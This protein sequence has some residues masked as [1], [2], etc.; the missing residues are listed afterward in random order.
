MGVSPST[1]RRWEDPE[2][3][4]RAVL[5]GRER[6]RERDEERDTRVVEL[7]TV[8]ALLPPLAERGRYLTLDE[9]VV[10][11][12]HHQHLTQTELAELLGRNKSTICRELKRHC[13]IHPV[14]DVPSARRYGAYAADR[15]AAARRARPQPRKLETDQP[16]HAHVQQQLM[17][18]WSPEQ[19]AR[20][21]PRVFPEQPERHLC[22]ETIYQALYVQ[23][24]GELRRQIASWLRSGRAIRRPRRHPEAR[25][26]RFSEPMVMVSERPAEV[27]DRAVPGHWEG[28]LIIGKDN[29]SAMVTLVER[30]TRFTMLAALPAGRDALAVRDAL[31]ELFTALPTHLARSLTWDQG[32]EMARHHEVRAATDLEVY[33][34]DPA[35]PWMRGSNENTNGLLRQYFPKG[36]DLS[37]HTPEHLTAVAAELNGRPRKTLD[38]D[39]PA[40]RLASLLA[41]ADE[42]RCCDD[43]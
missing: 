19:I 24:R 18:R 7:A 2:Q 42:Q 8:V 15:A 32:S 17:K 5:R 3:A 16:L 37:V 23:G 41:Q 35:S 4:Q 38:W 36:T 29:G 22:H 12:D 28:D 26:P 13:Y 6:A 40:E 31:I 21:L 11:A 30:S 10:I 43:A 27:A 1:V 33:F 34:C 9:R 20:T 39:S 14:K 25:T